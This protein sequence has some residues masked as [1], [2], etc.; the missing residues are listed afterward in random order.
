MSA[1]L[2][3]AMKRLAKDK[4]Q[5]ALADLT[6]AKGPYLKEIEQNALKA[7]AERLLG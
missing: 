4:K 5:R 3:D 6:Y 2:A 7:E 1:E